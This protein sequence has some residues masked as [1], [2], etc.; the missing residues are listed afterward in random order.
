MV[1]LCN[2]LNERAVRACFIEMRSK[3]ELHSRCRTTTT[4]PRMELWKPPIFRTREASYIGSPILKM[5]GQRSGLQWA[6]IKAD[7]CLFLFP[8]KAK[9]LPT[10]E[11]IAEIF[12]KW[13]PG[14]NPAPWALG[15]CR[16]VRGKAAATCWCLHFEEGLFELILAKSGPLPKL[17]A[18]GVSLNLRERVAECYR[19][20]HIF[21]SKG[22]LI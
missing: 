11:V 7:E 18:G 15:R 9:W 12:E 14:Q 2:N 8:L 3:R 19:K 20:S 21:F 13:V 16:Q 6:Q 1:Q 22:K 5:V 4:I 10:L 17:E